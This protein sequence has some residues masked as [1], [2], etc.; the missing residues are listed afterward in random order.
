MAGP[1]K[2]MTD[3]LRQCIVESGEAYIAL[4]RAT[5]V[6][7][8]SIMRFVRGETSLR[9]DLADKLAAHFGLEVVKRKGR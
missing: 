6:K 8:A 4:E 5:G 3:T 1:K 2:S 9:L 7:R